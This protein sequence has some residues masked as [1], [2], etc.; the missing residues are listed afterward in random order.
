MGL[1]PPQA[2]G[3]TAKTTPKEHLTFHDDRPLV[4]GGAILVSILIALFY[5][6]VI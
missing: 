4:I 6:K 5:L 1:T 2:R 3:L